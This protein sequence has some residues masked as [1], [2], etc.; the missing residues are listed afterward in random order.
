V[1]FLVIHV[2]GISTKLQLYKHWRF[3]IVNTRLI[4]KQ[5]SPL[6]LQ[7]SISIASWI[8]FYILIEHHGR[9]DLAIS[10][11]MRSIFGIFNIFT[12]AF[13][14][15][16]NAMVSNIIGQGKQDRVEELIGKIV[17]LSLGFSL[18]IALL[19]NI[20]PRAF[21]IIYGQ[22]DSFTE[23]AIPVIR[24]LSGAL[25]LMSFGTIWLNA[26]TGTGNSRISLLIE[27]ITLVFYCFY[28]YF[29]LERW[30]MSIVAGWMSEWVY[31]TSTF[32]FAFWYIRSGRWRGKV[33]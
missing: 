19:L 28:V 18:V 29:V 17:K 24:V 26:V 13:A 6:V 33:I 30:Q 4:L 5:S 25:I 31:W 20:F 12:W 22:D 23:A 7:Y 2:K 3:D 14:T 9:Q 11:T 10:N 15:T 16:T 1:V 8:F 27:M 32:I 21:L